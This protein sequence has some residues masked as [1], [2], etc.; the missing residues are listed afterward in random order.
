MIGGKH[1]A[2]AL[3]GLALV[4]CTGKVRLVTEAKQVGA[5]LE[6]KVD[7]NPS[8]S[9]TLTFKGQPAFEKLG[10]QK[11]EP[12][13]PLSLSVPLAGVPAGKNAVALHFEG[14]GKGL[15]KTVKGDDTL[16]FDRKA[17]TPEPWLVAR[18][19][20]PGGTTLPCSGTI[21]GS[22]SLPLGADGN[23]YVDIK[24]CDGCVIDAGGQKVTVKGDPSPAVLDI[25]SAAANVQ[26][27]GLNG[28]SDAKIPLTI[29]Q[30]SD[31]GEQAIE[32]KAPTLLGPI[33]ARVPQGGVRFAGENATAAA[34][35]K[36]AVLVRK[37]GGLHFRVVGSATKLRDADLIG[38]VT[39]TEK[40]L[41]TCGVYEGTTTKKK[42]TVEHTGESF[43][44]TLYDRR[45]GKSVAHRLF[46]YED[47]GCSD[48]LYTTKTTSAPS[49]ATVVA[50]V[51]GLLR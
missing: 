50:W 19:A 4:A 8:T 51:K 41:G 21:C 42:V 36:S 47:K 16:T 33:L 27:A 18:P 25:T 32:G 11:I 22:T 26:I 39:A 1:V 34:A 7:V 3:G 40:S 28:L 43:D 45:T 31:S 17:A 20:K 44:I 35:P 49:D 24:R 48:T 2:V 46:P 30:G 5:T 9:G 23:L 13:Q 12:G 38:I 14:Q 15:A 6:L 37:D 29:T 10:P